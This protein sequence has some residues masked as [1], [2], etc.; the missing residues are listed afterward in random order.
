M[1]IEQ[2]RDPDV[3]DT[4]VEYPGAREPA[5]CYRIDS[6]GVHIAVHEWGDA[7]APAVMLVHGGFDFA[8]TY[9]VFA[10]LLARAGWRTVAWDQR[11]HGD[12]GRAELYSWD[13]D[14]RD[15]LAVM[16]SIGSEPIPVIGHSKGGAMMIQLA[17]ARPHRFSHLVNLDGVPYKRAARGGHPARRAD[18]RRRQVPPRLAGA[19]AAEPGV[20]DASLVEAI[21]MY[22]DG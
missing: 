15:A 21:G 22:A 6:E 9:S 13:S 2:Q 5:R 18:R 8:R 20:V 7:D 1:T 16:D 4:A 12:S 3:D 17:D 19:V 10:P 14:M 11:G